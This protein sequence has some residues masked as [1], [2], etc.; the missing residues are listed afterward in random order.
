VLSPYA[1]S[2]N[3]ALSALEQRRGDAT[4]SVAYARRAVEP[5][6]N[7]VVIVDPFAFYHLG[8]GRKVGEAWA[9]YYAGLARAQ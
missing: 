9:A 7:D 4:L 5:Q 3:L 2:V 6:G 8:R 1:P